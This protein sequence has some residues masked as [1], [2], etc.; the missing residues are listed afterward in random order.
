MSSKWKRK[1]KNK[2]IMIDGYIMRSVAWASLTPNDKA[3]YL[4]IK[5]AFDGLNN[6]RIGM[7]CR[8]LADALGTSKDTANRSLGNLQEKG[9]IAMTRASGFNVKNRAASEWRLT[10]YACNVTGEL[11]TKEFMRWNSSEKTTVAPQGHTVSPQGQWGLERRA[12]SG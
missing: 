12:K 8:E 6:G 11:P 7:G 4:A 9:F 10:E 5:W 3:A 1:G 2:F